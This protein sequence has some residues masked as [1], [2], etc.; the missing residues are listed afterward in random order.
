VPLSF[1][2][3]N[4]VHENFRASRYRCSSLILALAFMLTA[5][6]NSGSSSSFPLA[7]ASPMSLTISSP[8]F[9]NGGKIDKKFTCEGADVSPRLQWGE[10]PS[11]TKSFALLVDDP[12]APAGNWNHWT[13]WNIPSAS[14]GLEEGISKKPR[15]PDGT[16]QG[17]NDFK[18]IGYNGPCPPAGKPH[19]YFFKLFALD[20]NLALKS[21]AG[22]PELESAMK[23]HILA[24]GEWMGQYQ[25]GSH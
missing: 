21:D 11:G 2:Q 19:R 6:A 17:T 15:L 25:R 8:S 5:R 16:Q 3:Q 14:H 18:K 24:E 13:A 9:S 22:K 4:S 1:F 7:G 10:P 23:G 20:K 12:D